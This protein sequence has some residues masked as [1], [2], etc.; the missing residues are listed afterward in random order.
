MENITKRMKQLQGRSQSIPGIEDNGTKIA[1]AKKVWNHMAAFFSMRR[2]SHVRDASF[3]RI[4]EPAEQTIFSFGHNHSESYN[5]LFTIRQL[6]GPLRSV[7]PVLPG[8]DN[9]RNEILPHFRDSSLTSLLQIFNHI[10]VDHDFPEQWRDASYIP[11]LKIVNPDLPKFLFLK[12]C[13]FSVS[14]GAT[15]YEYAA[16]FWL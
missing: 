12:K 4:R 8:P 13:I 7:K 16:L 6:R 5:V 10:W 9:I 2:S 1:D 11:I 15:E 14:L 3:R